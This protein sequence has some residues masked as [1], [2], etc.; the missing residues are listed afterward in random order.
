[1]AFKLTAKTKSLLNQ[2]SK[3]P[4]IVIEVE[5]V[6]NIFA[7][8]VVFESVTWDDGVTTWDEDGITWDGARPTDKFKPYINLRESTN[9]ITQQIYPDKKGSSSITQMRVS[10]VDKNGV[11]ARSFAKD[12]IGEILGKKAEINLGFVGGVYKRDF[13]PV[14]QGI[15]T[16]FSYKGG[17]ILMTISHSDTLKRQSALAPYSST[18]TANL[19]IG[20]TTIDVES[21]ANLLTDQDAL[22]TYIRIND[23]ICKVV[24]IVSDT[25][26]EVVRGEL[27]TIEVDHEQNDDIISVYRLQ[28]S[29][30]VLAQKLMQSDGNQSFFDSDITLISFNYVDTLNSIPNA[31]IFDIE[32][33]KSSTGLIAGDIVQV[34][35]YGDFTVDTFGQ[36]DDGRSYIIVN[37]TL[38]TVNDVAQSWRFKSQYNVLNFGLGMLP[39]EVDNESFEFIKSTFAPNFT[40]LDFRFD[41]GIESLRDFI[42]GELYFISGCVGIPRNARSSITFLSPPLT[43]EDLPVLNADTVNNMVALNPM[44]ST[45]NF[46][47]NDILFAFNKSIRDGKFKSFTQYID[48]DSKDTFAVGLKQLRLSSDGLR[49]SSQTDLILNRLAQR[50]LD[51]YS[52]AAIHIKGVELSLK[53]GFN[54]NVGDVVVFGGDST[55]LV[56]FNTGLRNLPIA[57]YEII[58][59]SIDLRGMVKVDLLST[60][61]A[62]RGT[63]G[64]FSPSSRVLSGST[65]TRLILGAINNLDEFDVERDKYT[66]LIGAKVRVRSDDY[67]YDETTTIT[68][69]DDQ[70]LQAILVSALPSTPPV[71]AILE[72][73]TYDEFDVYGVDEVHDLIKIKYTFNMDQDEITVQIDDQNFEIAN[74]GDFFIGQS[75]AIHSDDFTRDNLV[76][77]ISNISGSQITLESPL[78]FTPQVG[79]K[80]ESREKPDLDGYLFL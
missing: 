79:D 71:N 9:A 14:M 22:T 1:M 75:V 13:M 57:K 11:V 58:N 23:E 33:I 63:F 27:N 78:D 68:D 18:L 62:I 69:F 52:Q 53:N 38:P 65:T 46:Y 28:G 32:D 29:P 24:N 47:Y 6:D 74:P 55:K 35:T 36:L 21:T 66:R 19:L 44:R 7:S 64:V 39:F 34:D 70:N 72:L 2:I 42:N 49:R 3:N 45:N 76:S 48:D 5:G 37:E 15:I 80:I 17:A 20:V 31:M 16:S 60:N 25:Q 40:D 51:R 4:S 10:F 54:L 59:Q 41:D 50:F 8:S 77:T 43:I 73:A 67:T 26:L 61:F 12:N 56:D 30:L